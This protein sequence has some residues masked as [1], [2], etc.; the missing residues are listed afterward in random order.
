MGL[1]L[2]LLIYFIPIKKIFN[3]ESP[4]NQSAPNTASLTVTD[5]PVVHAPEVAPTTTAVVN[6]P[7]AEQNKQAPDV[8]EEVK[9]PEPIAA[10]DHAPAK[11]AMVEQ[12][13]VQPEKSALTPVASAPS[14][15]KF[16]LVGGCFKIRENADKLAEDLTRKGYHAQVSAMGKGFFRV[17]VDSYQTRKEAEQALGKLLSTD[18]EGGYWLMAD[19]K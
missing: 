12:K 1:P 7:K 11:P 14:K 4:G 3:G 10:T 18:P 13:A 17:S 8:K 19:K 15:G 9:L 2:L 16:H 5:S 6:E